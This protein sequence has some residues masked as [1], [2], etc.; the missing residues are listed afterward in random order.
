MLSKLTTFSQFYFF[1]Q[2]GKSYIHSTWGP[3]HRQVC[4]SFDILSCLSLAFI[5]SIFSPKVRA[6]LILLGSPT[7]HKLSHYLKRY[8]D[9]ME[10]LNT[11]T[12]HNPVGKTNDSGPQST[13]YSLAQIHVRLHD[14][15]ITIF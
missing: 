6:F 2:T 3:M 4:R 11:I 15:A 5:I 12:K 14:L 9:C 1:S 10:P 8:S 13:P 7:F